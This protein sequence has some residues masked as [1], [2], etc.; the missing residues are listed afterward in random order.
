MRDLNRLRTKYELRLDNRQIAYL[1]AGAVVVLAVV[2]SLGV[3]IGKRLGGMSGAS[4]LD[5]LAPLAAVTPGAADSLSLSSSF[6]GPIPAQTPP[7]VFDLTPTAPT[8]DATPGP[9]PADLAPALD[10]PGG[11]PV[12]PAPADTAPPSGSFWT[13]QVGSYPTLGEAQALQQRMAAAG[14]QA[15]IENN[16]V[17]GRGLRYRV[18][19]GNFESRGAA[20][21]V[22]GALRERENV[23]TWV[24]RYPAE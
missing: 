20:N 12:P 16:E 23:D 7:Q 15:F 5:E 14:N 9:S 2:F 3:V 6:G 11:A 13:V 24:R 21:A 17:P 4:P 8:S 1:L 10:H 18:L 19:V 22:A